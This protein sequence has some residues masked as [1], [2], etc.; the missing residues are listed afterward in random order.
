MAAMFPYDGAILA[1]VQAKP[2]NIAGVFKIM[3]TIDATCADADGLKW[4]NWLYLDVESI[5]DFPN[6]L[7]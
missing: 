4:F 3:Q 2:Q 7:P 5:D 1:A 6:L